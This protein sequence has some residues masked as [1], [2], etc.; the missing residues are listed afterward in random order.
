MRVLVPAALC[1]A[2]SVG[3]SA[4]DGPRPGAV[5]LNRPGVLE[6][7]KRH[8]PARYAAIHDILR[9]SARYPCQASALRTL[10]VRWDLQD[11]GCGATLL[12]SY[13]AQRLLTFELQ[14]TLY[15]AR[16]AVAPAE[17]LEPAHLAR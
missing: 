3:A 15:G 4:L 13:P 11:V 7:I 12:A 16:V 9:V 6:Q 10:R 2:F 17:R 8:D 1:L 14:G 5:D